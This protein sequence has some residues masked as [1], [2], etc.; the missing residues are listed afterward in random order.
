MDGERRVVEA[1]LGPVRYL[2]AVLGQAVLHAFPALAGLSTKS[3]CDITKAYARRVGFDGAVYGHS[4]RPGFSPAQHVAGLS[5]QNE[6]CVPA[7]EHGRAREPCR[8]TAEE[9][10]CQFELIQTKRHPCVPRR[11]RST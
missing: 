6:G 2:A 4:L 11:G 1:D 9:A 8:G 10:C 7:Q 5:I 3:V